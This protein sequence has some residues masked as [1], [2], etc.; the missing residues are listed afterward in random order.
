V[1]LP[2]GESCDSFSLPGR[3]HPDEPCRGGSKAD[4]IFSEPPAIPAL[5]DIFPEHG[6][7]AVVDETSQP[8]P[9]GFE[10]GRD[11]A[12]HERSRPDPDRVGGAEDPPRPTGVK[13]T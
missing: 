1:R 12:P 6:Y 9:G 10:E 2:A 3:G 7:H 8:M 13:P 4:P 11:R 5:I